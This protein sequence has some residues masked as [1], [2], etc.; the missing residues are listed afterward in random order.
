MKNSKKFL[1]DPDALVK[2]HLSFDTSNI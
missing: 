1:I 2:S